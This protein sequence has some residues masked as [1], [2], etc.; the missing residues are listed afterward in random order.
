VSRQASEAARLN[1]FDRDEWRDVARLV[2][3][4]L[5]EEQFDRL[6]S[7]FCELKRRRGLQ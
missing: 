3:P 6:W 4:E 7:E 1:E 5:N 2:A